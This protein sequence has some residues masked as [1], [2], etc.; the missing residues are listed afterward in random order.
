MLGRMLGRHKELRFVA[1]AV[2]YRQDPAME[3]EYL[4]VAED[5]DAAG[6]RS[7][8]SAVSRPTPTATALSAPM[9]S[10]S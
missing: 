1:V 8:F 6:T 4:V 5:P 9:A 2:A 3:A 10:A 7:R